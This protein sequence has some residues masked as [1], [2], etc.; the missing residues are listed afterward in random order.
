MLSNLKALFKKTFLY[1]LLNYYRSIKEKK[2]RAATNLYKINTVKRY[3]AEHH[4]NI[5][6]ETGTYLGETIEACKNLFKNLISIELNHELSERAKAHFVNDPHIKIYEGDSGILLKEILLP[7]TEPCLFWLDGHYSSGITS[8]GDLN[9]PI[10]R[11]LEHIF[12]HPVHN[13]VILID[14]ARLFVGKDDYPSIAKLEKK[15]QAYAP[16]FKVYVKGDIIR[17]HL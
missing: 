6:I 8:K 12:K 2:E 17:I 4:I 13:H 9:T 14:D 1:S 5:L 15:V 10:L 3:A 11:E 16:D 7:I